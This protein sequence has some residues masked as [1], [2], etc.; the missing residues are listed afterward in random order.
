MPD[1]GRRDSGTRLGDQVVSAGARRALA[2]AIVVLTTVTLAVRFFAETAW[3]AAA[4]RDSFCRALSPDPL[5]PKLQGLAPDF[6]L[7][8]AA[9]KRWSLRALRD[10]PMLVSF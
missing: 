4:A 10:R 1:K 6:E 5:S 9:G 7:A 3:T 2:I 8:D